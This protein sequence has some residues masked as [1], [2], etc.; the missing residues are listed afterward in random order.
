VKLGAQDGKLFLRGPLRQIPSKERR[1]A[2]RS[3][4]A[5][6]ELWVVLALGAGCGEKSSTGAPSAEANA[7]RPAAGTHDPLRETLEDPI[8]V[9]ARGD[10]E[11]ARKQ[12]AEGSQ[13]YMAGRLQKASQSFG[14]ALRADEG[15]PVALY[16]M[17][18]TSLQRGPQQNALVALRSFRIL[19]VLDPTLVEKEIHQ[20][21]VLREIEL[22]EARAR[23]LLGDRSRSRA[24]IESLRKAESEL[25]EP[26]RALLRQSEAILEFQ[27]GRFS[28]A[29]AAIDAALAIVADE[30]EF[31]S[32]RAQILEKLDR[33]D[34]AESAIR[35]ALETS[36]RSAE[37]HFI[38]C[39]LLKR[40]QR[41]D[42]A[43]REQTIFELLQPF[44]DDVSAGFANDHPR[45]IE[46]RSR[47][48]EAYPEFKGARLLL[49]RELA[50]ARRHDH[51]LKDLESYLKDQPSDTEAL[52]LQ[53]GCLLAIG[54]SAGARASADLMRAA[55]AKEA[56]YAD[57]IRQIDSS[58]PA[59][60]GE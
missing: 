39:R 41:T 40:L 18:T 48:I 54:D 6:P 10:V 15:N 31:H 45:R 4:L 2:E 3:L 13:H 44:E 36:P 9:P 29:L 56:V 38:R 21:G 34:P 50:Q 59:G 8:A 30:S 26:L 11:E 12:I 32:W 57:L 5:G 53:A 55:G 47:L 35:T 25:S 23:V 22:N 16:L 49:V 20:P 37:L 7:Q 33:F 51:A 43:A 14:K 19:R 42:E 17:G 52:F 28:E 1:V 60:D 27:E 58:S 24:L 46:L